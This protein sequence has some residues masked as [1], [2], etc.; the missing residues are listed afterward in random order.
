M[1]L[2]S[3]A[4]GWRS[5]RFAPSWRPLRLFLWRLSPYADAAMRSILIRSCLVALYALVLFGVGMVLEQ[6]T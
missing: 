2:G 6:V 4:E 5:G 3:I 1:S